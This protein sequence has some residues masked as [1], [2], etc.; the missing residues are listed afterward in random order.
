MR[1]GSWQTKSVESFESHVAGGIGSN[2]QALPKSLP[3]PW[4]ECG[5]VEQKKKLTKA[6]EL[7]DKT[8]QRNRFFKLRKQLFY[9]VFCHSFRPEIDALSA[10]KS[11]VHRRKK[12]RDLVVLVMDTVFTL[13]MVSRGMM[14]PQI[15]RHEKCN[16]FGEQIV[17]GRLKTVGERYKLMS[18]VVQC[19]L[20]L[21]M[22]FCISGWPTPRTYNPSGHSRTLFYIAAN[23]PPS[24]HDKFVTTY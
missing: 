9:Q 23:R 11:L 22:E 5:Y 16:E 8:H 7:Y 2:P 14:L 21:F 6:T 24:P 10:W 19:L 12:N 20:A 18:G 1:A 15:K 4:I 13:K 3:N 17:Y